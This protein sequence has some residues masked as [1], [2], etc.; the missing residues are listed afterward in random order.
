[1][2]VDLGI[3]HVTRMRRIVICGLLGSTIFFDIISKRARFSNKKYITVYKM[4]VLILSTNLSETF[5]RI[6]RDLIKNVY[7]SSHKLPV[8]LVRF[9]ET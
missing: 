8:I 3:Q 5:L 9:H 4:C 1:M 2:F 6:Q 7:W